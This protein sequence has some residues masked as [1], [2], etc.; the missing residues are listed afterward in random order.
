MGAR[1]WAIACREWLALLMALFITGCIKEA[2]Q[3][4]ARERERE[5]WRLGSPTMDIGIAEGDERLELSGASSSIRLEDGRVVIANSGTNELRVFDNHGRFQN[6]IGRKGE[7]P[8]EFAGALHVVRLSEASFAVFDQ[9]NQRLSIFDTTGR[10]LGESRVSSEGR[11]DFPLW[12]WLYRRAWVVGPADTLERS[13]IARVLNAMPPVSAGSYRFVQVATDG[14]LWSQTRTAES[15]A[16]PPWDVYS[17]QGAPLGSITFPPA[18]EIHQI[19]PDYVLLRTW[20]RDDV[21]HIQLYPFQAPAARAQPPASDSGSV[22]P[23]DLTAREIIATAL[24]NL[25]GAQEMFYMDSAAYA[26]RATS[27]QWERP[28]E[29]SLHL[30]AADKRGWAG[31]LVHSTE[32]VLCGMAVGG[33]TPPGW[34]EGTPKCSR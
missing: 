17:T 25:V 2:T 15:T 5:V 26:T 9:G 6:S 8:G 24:R 11:S 4:A 32:P 10:V 31:L 3:S 29:T 7:G 28:K 18:A 14:R 19:G 33:S 21:E 27:L 30:L 13:R 16:N 20:G 23:A 34:G 12:V 1:L 22:R